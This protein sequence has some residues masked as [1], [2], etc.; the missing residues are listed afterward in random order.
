MTASQ[1][2]FDRNIDMLSSSCLVSWTDTSACYHHLVT[3]KFLDMH[4][5]TLIIMCLMTRVMSRV[6]SLVMCFLHCGM[7][8]LYTARMH[9]LYHGSHARSLTRLACT[10]FDT[11][12]PSW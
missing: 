11:M 9:A 8:A 6:M 4:I 12:D 3:L 1:C 10:L 2:E 5:I 7:N